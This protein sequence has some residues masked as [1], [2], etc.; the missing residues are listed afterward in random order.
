MKKILVWIIFCLLFFQLV[1]GRIEIGMEKYIYTFYTGE[2]GKIEV[3]IKNVG[4][5]TE[6]LSLRIYPQVF[7]GIA[8]SLSDYYIILEPGEEKTVKIIFYVPQ[9]LDKRVVENLPYSFTFSALSLTTNKTY[10]K[11]FSVVFKSLVFAKIVEIK[12]VPKEVYPN[13]KVLIISKIL[14]YRKEEEKYSLKLFVKHKNTVF[15]DEEKEFTLTPYSSYRYLKEIKISQFDPPGDYKVEIYLYHDT[16]LI[17]KSFVKFRVKKVEKVEQ[18]KKVEYGILYSKVKIFLENKGNVITNY[19]VTEEFP[20]IALAFM[21]FV[22]P[23]KIKEGPMTKI[24][25]TLELKPGEKKA[26]EYEIV[27]W[28]YVLAFSF[29]GVLAILVLSFYFTPFIKK[30]KKISENKVKVSIVVKNSSRKPI[31]DVVVKD[32][33]PAIYKIEKR[34][35]TMKPVI[36]KVKDGYE[37]IWR[38]EKMMPGEERILSYTIVLPIEIIGKIKLPKAK[39]RFTDVNKKRRSARSSIFYKL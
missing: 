30:Q 15:W 34:F 7:Y 13:E 12:T 36:R 31:R 11:K 3:K 35:E 24:E 4:Y 23:P 19:T 22:L 14:N 25:W 10:E 38:I 27:V 29:G 32:F 2:K 26:I 37:L 39:M 8:I 1:F 33:V 18:V 21:K 5:E 17:D 28:P 16:T 9:F 20:G 6:K